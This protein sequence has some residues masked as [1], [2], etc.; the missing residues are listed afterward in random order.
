MVLTLIAS[1]GNK[2][3]TYV[4]NNSWSGRITTPW[5]RNIS[6]NIINKEISEINKETNK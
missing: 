4:L 2:H 6:A 5:G 3:M 1:R